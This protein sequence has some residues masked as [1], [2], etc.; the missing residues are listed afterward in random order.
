[1]A[2]MNADVMAIYANVMTLSEKMNYLNLTNV[3]YD[4]HPLH[5]QRLPKH[6]VYPHLPAPHLHVLHGHNHVP[7]RAVVVGDQIMALAPP[8]GVCFSCIPPLT[9]S[10]TPL[11]NSPIRTPPGTPPP[12]G[13]TDHQSGHWSSSSNQL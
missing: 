10:G 5:I 6:H 2:A 4:H 11:S 13:R 12:L 7:H 1:M 8:L 3:G 9:L